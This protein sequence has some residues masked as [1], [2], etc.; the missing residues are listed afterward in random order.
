MANTDDYR[1]CDG[2]NG[3]GEVFWH[4]QDAT[5]HVCHGKGYI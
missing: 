1:D 4:G 3:T 5:C 2:C